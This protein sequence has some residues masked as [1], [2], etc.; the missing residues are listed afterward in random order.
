MGDSTSAFLF[1]NGLTPF[2]NCSLIDP[3]VSYHTENVASHH[4][5]GLLCENEFVSRIG[6]MQHWGVAYNNYHNDWETHRVFN[7]TTNSRTNILKTLKEYKERSRKGQNDGIDVIFL[8]NLWEAARML[9]YT[10]TLDME[11]LMKE[12]RSNMRSM[13]KEMLPLLESSDR[14]FLQTAHL[15]T[16]ERF[17]DY[18]P[19]INSE[20]MMIACEFNLP[21]FREDLYLGSPT[22]N[23]YLRDP[24]HQNGTA[25]LIVTKK[26]NSLLYKNTN[27]R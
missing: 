8:S 13:L 20:I 16:A 12:Y 2:F 26:L 6:Y 1:R 21:L 7:D 9:K 27:H 3:L 4:H 22:T 23:N 24:T 25:S 15:V 17:K 14:L 11:D 18:I 10:D 5:T 19:F